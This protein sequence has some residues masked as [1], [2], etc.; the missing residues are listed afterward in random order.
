MI[1]I[2]EPAKGTNVAIIGQHG[3]L[4]L[5][6]APDPDGRRRTVHGRAPDGVSLHQL[7]RAA[8]EGRL[9]FSGPWWNQV[10]AVTPPPPKPSGRF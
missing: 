4:V 3:R 5:L 8:R 2:P 9:S 10:I 1:Q 6:S 7:R